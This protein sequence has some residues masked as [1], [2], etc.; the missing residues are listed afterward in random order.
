MLFPKLHL[1]L[2]L[3]LSLFA[4]LTS[5]STMLGCGGKPKSVTTAQMP[6]SPA[7]SPSP[8]PGASADPGAPAVA[9]T[10]SNIEDLGN[11]Q[12]CTRKLNGTACASGAGNANSSMTPRQS[13]P[14][15]DG[16]SARFSISGP[17]GYSNALWWNSFDNNSSVSHF[18][19]DLW[20]YIDRP[21][22][23]EALEFDVNQSFGGIRYTWGTECAFKDSQKWDIW[24]AA[25]FK[26]VHTSLP[27]KPF[28]ANTWHH[29]VWQFE[30]VNHQMH[31]ISLT[32]DGN[33]M[34]VDI[35]KDPQTN[36]NFDDINVAFQLDGDIKQSPYNVWLD[37]VN[38]T[39]W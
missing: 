38:L 16:S 17:T 15:R 18:T 13:T 11:W 27:C 35:Y 36:W 26:W 19:Y 4:G 29:I 5:V 23:S 7:A 10:I 39:M 22:V 24:D 8:L 3:L 12:S 9:K 31:Y 14:A 33:T 34:P 37:Q 30:R 20:F 1:K 28:P 2:C 32:V 21:E 25:G 6:P